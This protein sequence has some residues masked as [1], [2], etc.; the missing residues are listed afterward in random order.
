MKK[1]RKRGLR[2]IEDVIETI[3]NNKSFFITA[4][5]NLEGDAL[6]SELAMYL[7]LKKLNKKVVICNNDIT[8]TMYN[9]LPGVVNVRNILKERHFDV[10]IALDCSDSSRTG[11]VQDYL[12][13]AKCIVN[14]DHH[15]SN[16]HFGDVNWVDPTASSACEIMYHLCHSFNL[17]DRDI[18]KCLYTGIYT[19][20]GSFTYANTTSKT[21][22]IIKHLLKYNINTSKIHDNIYSVCSI[23]DLK[24]I[25]KVIGGLKFDKKNKMC[26][27]VIKHWKDN[28]FD[29][30]EIIF[31]IMRLLKDVEVFLLFKKINKKEV[32]INFRSRSY[33]DVNRIAQ[34]FG[35][36]GH[37]NASGTTMQGSLSGV[38]RKVISFIKRSIYKGGVIKIKKKKVIKIKSVK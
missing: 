17:I 6:G 28:V 21:H 15:V 1:A 32:R 31:S 34:F 14:I 23:S 20:T 19:D 26:W 2:M 30:T 36:G 38:E 25:S 16:T 35:G 18:A 12:G 29:R 27:A 13:L 9:F 24:F 37:K 3:K 4:H 8:P 10:A 11:K 7:L 33:Y 5:V 22:E